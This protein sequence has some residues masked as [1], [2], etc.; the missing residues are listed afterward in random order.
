MPENRPS[1]ESGHDYRIRRSRWTGYQ[2][3]SKDLCATDL[4]LCSRMAAMR[5]IGVRRAVFLRSTRLLIDRC[6]A[7]L[8]MLHVLFGMSHAS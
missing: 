1:E 3:H 5:R 2:F 7:P 8:S 6:R 4:K